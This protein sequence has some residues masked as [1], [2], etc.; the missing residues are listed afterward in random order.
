MSNSVTRAP[1]CAPSAANSRAGLIAP[2]QGRTAA[3]PLPCRGRE[4]HRTAARPR[5]SERE[6]DTD[7]RRSG[8]LF[9]ARRH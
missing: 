9:D 6:R 2:R 7:E 5:R 3:P 8:N 4:E 1:S